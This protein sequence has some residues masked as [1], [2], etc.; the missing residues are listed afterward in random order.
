[1]ILDGQIL[2]DNDRNIKIIQSIC[3]KKGEI[4]PN[5]KI[6]NGQVW[7]Y[8]VQCLDCG[9]E[10]C[11]PRGKV[12]SRKDK[13]SLCSGRVVVQ[14]V[15]DLYTTNPSIIMFLSNKLEGYK[16]SK[17]SNKK[18]KCICPHC[19][20]EKD[21]AI[22]NLVTHG[23]YCDIC[24]DSISYPNKIFINI[25]QQLGVNFTPEYSPSWIGKK[26][27]DFYLED[28]GI[29]I[30]ADGEQ[31]MK[32]VDFMTS[33]E[34]QRETD[35]Y[36]DLMALKNNLRVIRIDCSKSELEFIKN[37]ILKSELNNILQLSNVNWEEVEK[38]A[39]SS[40]LLKACQLK[41]ENDLYTTSEIS[42]I[43]SIS[44]DTICRWLKTG[45]DLGLCSY[46][47]KEEMSRN[48]KRQ[49]HGDKEIVVYDINNNFLI[50]C[51][52][53]KELSDISK[54]KLGKYISRASISK[55]CNGHIDH[56]KGFI[57]K[58]K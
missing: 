46:N 51:S 49:Y 26:R 56:V 18:V 47:A 19:G 34:K 12:V 43:L 29:I 21:V 35:I 2:Q 5:G 48:G 33:F 42:E 50:E 31:H 39:I 11:S 37:N 13:C 53:I 20:Y 23:F 52:S 36:K 15:N 32:E 9:Y 25:L 16:Y 14:G 57:I 3:I 44:Q 17:G 28:Y 41:K 10:Y 30:E 58:F 38:F 7:W 1:M 4:Q 54:E 8:K 24:S 22:C 27:Y 55:C 45:N 6:A 40:L